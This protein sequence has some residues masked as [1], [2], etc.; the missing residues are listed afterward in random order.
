M[1]SELKLI[2]HH[3]STTVPYWMIM[4]ATSVL[5]EI[6]PVIRLRGVLVAFLLPG[7]PR[8]LRIGRN[9]TLLGLNRLYIGSNVYIAT[10]SWVNAIGEIVIGREVTLS[11][12]VI[13]ASTSHV[14]TKGTCFRT[15]V[16]AARIKIGDG[17]WIASHSVLCAGAE[18]GPGCIVGAG[19]VVTKKIPDTGKVIFGS[20]AKVKKNVDE[21]TASH[22]SALQGRSG[23]I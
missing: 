12:Y 7:C 9:V 15:G 5:P 3:L 17:S 10:G 23:V 11:P 6:G 22:F 20:P 1:Q 19:S 18:I 21:R 14:I 4:L 8:G 2:L 16:M 13:L